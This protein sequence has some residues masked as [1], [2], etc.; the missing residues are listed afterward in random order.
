M[1]AAENQPRQ[2]RFA[3]WQNR[4]ERPQTP[5]G[6]P[7][8]G[9]EFGAAPARR[10][11]AAPRRYSGA[12][13]KRD[14]RR[15]GPALLQPGRAG[16]ARWGPRPPIVAATHLVVTLVNLDNFNVARLVIVP[17]GPPFPP[18]PLTV[19]GGRA[20]LPA[21]KIGAKGCEI[22]QGGAAPAKRSADLG[23]RG[24]QVGAS[25]SGTRAAGAL[26][27]APTTDPWVAHRLLY[28]V[29]EGDMSPLVPPRGPKVV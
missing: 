20:A 13:H 9:N 15:T 18:V 21:G 22:P 5:Q 19:G 12:A 27:P 25:T 6:G 4:R 26:G 3:C 11:H 28:R 23:P 14:A 7:P 2:R 8:P 10:E 17:H 24:P 16:P 29:Y 1:T